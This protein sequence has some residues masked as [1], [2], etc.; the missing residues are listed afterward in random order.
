MP[1]RRCGVDAQLMRAERLRCVVCEDVV[2]VYEPIV[3]VDSA[4]TRVTSLACEPGLAQEQVVVRHRQCAARPGISEIHQQRAAR[5]DR[6][7]DALTEHPR[8]A[9]AGV[10]VR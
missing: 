1:C 4:G 10:H 7:D 3:V 6:A 9:G 2:G 5:S 8:A